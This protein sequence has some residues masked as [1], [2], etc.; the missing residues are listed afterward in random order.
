M[1]SRLEERAVEYTGCIPAKGPDSPD[2][3]PMYDIIPSDSEAPIMREFWW[4]WSTPSLPS[5]PHPLWPGVVV[6]DRVL[7][8]GQIEQIVSKQMTNDKLW[9]LYS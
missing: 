9:L 5:L 7:S 2:E 8:R 1:P 3:C 6:P 4:M